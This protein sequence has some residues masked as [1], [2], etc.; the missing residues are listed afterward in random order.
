MF[1]IKHGDYLSTLSFLKNGTRTIHWLL[2]CRIIEVVKYQSHDCCNSP[3]SNSRIIPSDIVGRS[4][5]KS[6]DLKTPISPLLESSSS[7]SKIF[8][9]SF[10]FSL[11]VQ[12]ASPSLPLFQPPGFHSILFGYAV[13]FTQLQIMVLVGF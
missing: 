2:A 4:E 12:N 6:W 5:S 9:Y 7:R 13:N 1:F 11:G 3:P 10:R 8:W